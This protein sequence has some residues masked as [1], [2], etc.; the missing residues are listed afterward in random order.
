[1]RGR[2]SPEHRLLLRAAL[3]RDE[4]ALADWRTWT[5]AVDLD[6]LSDESVQLLPLL[7]RNLSRLG[8]ERAATARYASVYRHSWASNRLTFRAVADAVARLDEAGIKT[9]LLKGGALALLH[10]GDLGVRSMLDVDVL[11]PQD[12][13]ADAR[14]VLLA[15]GWTKPPDDKRHMLTSN[16]SG[17]LN[18]DGRALDLHWF[19]NED[20]RT[21]RADEAFWEA[22]VPVE[23][24]G[25]HTLALAPTDLLY[26]VLV[27]AFLSNAPHVR[28]A[29]DATV[30]VNGSAVDW[31]RLEAVAVRRRMVLPVHAMLMWIR[32]ELDAGVPRLALERLARVS[33]PVI[34]RLE[35]R[36]LRSTRPYTAGKVLLR[37]WT[38]YRRSTEARGAARALGFVRFL[39]RYYDVSDPVTLSRVGVRRGLSRLME[40]RA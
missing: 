14:A 38:I 36:H 7:Y 30:I 21:P 1:M 9:M 8:V 40:H 28:W 39:Q 5:K 17:M 25:T 18:P 2:V 24:A 32:D 12:R 26:N 11:V 13:Y 29:A 4:R 31:A 33:V 27:H 37:L 22:A 20:A 10:Y 6:A 34:D 23:L 15:E 19:V 3:G 35:Y 16:G